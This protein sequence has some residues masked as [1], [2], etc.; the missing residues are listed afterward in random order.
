MRM[1]MVDPRILCRNH[2]LGEH[3]EHHMFIGTIKQKKKVTGYIKNN[4]FQP[5][6]LFERHNALVK[7]MQRRGYNH[8]SPITECD[9]DVCYLPSEYQYWQIDCNKSLNDLLKRCPECR[10]RYEDLKNE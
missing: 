5:R 2:L 6:A 8:K 3:L 4:C 9:C 10:K 7:E 1:W